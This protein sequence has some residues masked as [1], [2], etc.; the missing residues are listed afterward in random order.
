MGDEGGQ[1]RFATIEQGFVAMFGQPAGQSAEVGAIAVQRC[2]GQAVF[3]PQ[4]IAEIV[5]F[6]EISRPRRH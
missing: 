4:G 3:Q 6:G 1:R 5:D 2:L